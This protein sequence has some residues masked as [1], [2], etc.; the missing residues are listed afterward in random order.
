[1]R[2]RI[3]NSGALG[4]R[5]ARSEALHGIGHG[6]PRTTAAGPAGAI[7]HAEFEA[8]PVRL[9]HGEFKILPPFGTHE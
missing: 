3:E 5:F 2:P 8:E 9:L 7:F 4:A 6:V 1:M